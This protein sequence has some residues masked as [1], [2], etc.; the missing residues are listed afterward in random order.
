MGGSVG[1]SYY[2]V[3]MHLRFSLIEGDIANERKQFHLF[4]ENAGRVVLFRLPVEP[5]QLCVRK[6]ACPWRIANPARCSS[7]LIRCG[8]SGTSVQ[9][10]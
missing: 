5:T 1:A 3:R 4:I 10:R 8:D 2:H 7:E 9:A 6:S